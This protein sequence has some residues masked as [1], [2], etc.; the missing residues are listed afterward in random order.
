MESITYRDL[1]M[2]VVKTISVEREQILDQRSTYLYTRWRGSFVVTY[3]PGAESFRREGNGNP[4]ARAGQMPVVTDIAIRNHLSQPRGQLLM[5][6]NGVQVVSAP[7]SMFGTLP[8][9]DAATGPIVRVGSIVQ[10]SGE[11]LWQIQL[12]IEAAV[13]EF[14]AQSSQTANPIISNRWSAWSSTDWQHLTTREYQGTVIV[15]G[16]MLRLDQ[17]MQRQGVTGQLDSLRLAFAAFSVP[18]GFQRTSVRVRVYPDGNAADYWVTDTEQLWNKSNGCPAIRIEVQDSSWEHKGSAGVA[19]VQAVGGAGT[20]AMT[21][22]MIGMAGGPGGAFIGGAI[23]A[24]IGVA[25]SAPGALTRQLPKYYR[26]CHVRVWGNQRTNRLN[27]VSVA[28]GIAMNRL[29]DLGDEGALADLSTKDFLIAA[30]TNNYVD[31]SVVRNWDIAALGFAGTVGVAAFRHLAGQ[32]PDP[33]LDAFNRG[34]FQ[35][36]N[37]NTRYPGMGVAS[38]Q[39]SQQF[40]L[41]GPN[42]RFF[43]GRGTRGTYLEPLL[44]QTLEGFNQLPSLNLP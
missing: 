7:Q 21:G 10:I 9:C 31:V 1:R 42:P 18:A 38:V 36:P 32:E 33:G 8:P 25:T 37:T 41:I 5:V 19:A 15:R 44:I 43:G 17:V 24:I 23:G 28:L 16:D 30:D 12:E 6:S 2:T 29:F 27:L 13:N 22:A 4:F 39:Y 11:R 14:P 3:N 34:V 26:R 20:G 35:S 40:P